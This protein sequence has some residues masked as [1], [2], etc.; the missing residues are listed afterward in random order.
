MTHIQ[1]E[2]ETILITNQKDPEDAPIETTVLY[3][4]TMSFSA[5]QMAEHYHFTPMQCEMLEEL[6][7]EANN[8]W[9]DEFE[10]LQWA[11]VVPF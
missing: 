1:A 8:S 5:F 2:I 4:R 9:W 3:I 10:S 7:S 6:L 11:K